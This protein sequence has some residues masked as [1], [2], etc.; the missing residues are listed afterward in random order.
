MAVDLNNIQTGYLGQEGVFK[1]DAMNINEVG[2][3]EREAT[4]KFFNE[5]EDRAILDDGT[6]VFL[7]KDGSTQYVPQSKSQAE[8]DKSMVDESVVKDLADLKY[9]G[10]NVGASSAELNAAYEKLGLDS[11]KSTAFSDAN[12][13]LRSYGYKPGEQGSS[14]FGSNTS[15]DVSVNILVDRWDSKPSDEDLEAAGIDPSSVSIVNDHGANAA[16]L[17]EALVNQGMSLDSTKAPA[18][19]LV[20]ASRSARS[21]QNKEVEDIIK[22]KA[23]NSYWAQKMSE[24]GSSLDDLQLDMLEWDLIKKKA[25]E[26][27]HWCRYNWIHVCCR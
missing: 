21:A 2:E 26:K 13:I 4:R 25:E 6:L 20:S 15:E 22:D 18:S 8:V 5:S 24:T 12:A 11:S 19:R 23:P 16:Y 1:I 10:Q 7:D 17:A 9:L 27:K 14:F 3:Q